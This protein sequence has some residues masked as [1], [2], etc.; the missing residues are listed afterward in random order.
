MIKFDFNGL[1]PKSDE[2]EVFNDA[3]FDFTKIQPD[4]DRML[5]VAGKHGDVKNLIILARGG[6]VST[7]RAFWHGYGKYISDKKVYFVDTVDPDYIFYVKDKCKPQDSLVISISKSG[8]T[9]DVIENVLNFDGF[10]QVIITTDS[11]NPLNAIAKE[12]GYDT[13]S[14]QEVGGRFSGLTEV[15]LFP[16]VLCGLDI[17]E[18]RKGGAQG[19]VDFAKDTNDAKN[20]ALIIR[21]LSEKKYD[22][23]FWPIYSRKLVAFSGLIAQ[24]INETVAKEGKG[25]STVIAEGPESQ[26]FLNQRFFGGPKNMIGIFTTVAGFDEEET[27]AVPENLKS[28][29]LRDGNVGNLDGM[30]L[31]DSMRFELQGTYEE[32]KN[33][34]IPSLKMEIDKVDEFN[35]GYFTA[36]LHVFAIYL[37]RAFEVNPFDQPE[38][39]GSKKISFEARKNYKK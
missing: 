16:S 17:S 21:E 25:I 3:D 23:I 22:Q 33:S 26:H 19:Y 29:K 38:V 6:S 11:D 37:A 18:I 15:S 24:L 2:V 9:V 14:H 36:Y 7:F 12:K 34:K 32:A 27:V 35:L 39:E 31:S 13:L 8:T 20:L 1:E 30:K 10:T 28:V 4:M 5:E